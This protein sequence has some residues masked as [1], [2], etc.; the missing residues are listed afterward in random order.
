M[1]RKIP[2]LP[3]AV[4]LTLFLGTTIASYAQQPDSTVQPLYTSFYDGAPNTIYKQGLIIKLRSGIYFEILDKSKLKNAV[5]NPAVRAYK[6][7]RKYALMVQGIPLPIKANLIQDVIESNID[8][9]FKGWDGNTSWKLVNGETWQ[10]DEYGNL[11]ANLYRPKVFIFRMADGS[12]KMSITGVEPM[13]VV[14]K[15]EAKNVE[16]F[17]VQAKDELQQ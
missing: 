6:D 17:K 7:G 4:L 13:L 3:L 9:D 5:P 11:Y 16:T 12:Y 15:G 8:G 14:K 2:V 10:Q 1:K